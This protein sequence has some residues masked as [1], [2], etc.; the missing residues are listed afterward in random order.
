RLLINL[1]ISL[2]A[3]VLL[4]VGLAGLFVGYR[5]L[6]ANRAGGIPLYVSGVC[7][8]AVLL[9]GALVFTLPYLA[10]QFQPKQHGLLFQNFREDKAVE[11]AKANPPAP[12]KGVGLPVPPAPNPLAIE[13]PPFPGKM[14]PAVKAAAKGREMKAMRIIAP[15]AKDQEGMRN[16]GKG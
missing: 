14:N 6:H 1:G 10:E 8:L 11:M 5:R 3:C 2:T 4:L 15:G 9:I 13:P 16:P 12:A 7:S